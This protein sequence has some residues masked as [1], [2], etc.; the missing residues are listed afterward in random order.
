[1]EGICEEIQNYTA[2]S[3]TVKLRTITLYRVIAPRAIDPN[4]HYITGSQ[5]LAFIDYQPKFH[6]GRNRGDRVCPYA[7]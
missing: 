5:E 7:D 6:Y 4:T 1:M 3:K 2:G